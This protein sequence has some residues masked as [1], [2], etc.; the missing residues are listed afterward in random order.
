MTFISYNK[1]ETS[2]GV[3]M[4]DEK[5]MYEGRKG[6]KRLKAI[7]KQIC[8]TNAEF[9]HNYQ[10]SPEMIYL[11]QEIQ[12]EGTSKLIFTLAQR[13]V[14]FRWKGLRDYG[15]LRLCCRW[16]NGRGLRTMTAD[17]AAAMIKDIL[18]RE[19]CSS[20]DDELAAADF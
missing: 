3:V 17:A 1:E 7:E 13:D 4:A 20:L 18:P 9:D 12:W 19:M 10:D 11:G 5:E 8:K 16:I 15:Y 2:G 6:Q 14:N